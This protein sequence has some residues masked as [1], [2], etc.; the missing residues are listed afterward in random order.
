MKRIFAAALAAAV[1]LS[2]VFAAAGCA[3][4]GGGD[5]PPDYGTL[6]IADVSVAV[7]E[8][9]KLEPVFSKGDPLEITY[10]FD[11]SDIRIEDDTV[12]A[13]VADKTV[14]VTATTEHHSTTFTVTTTPPDYGKLVINDV[15]T[16][17]DYFPSDFVPVYTDADHAGTEIDYEYDESL[18]SLDADN[19]TVTAL[20]AGTATVKATLGAYQT[21]FTVNCLPAVSMTGSIKRSFPRHGKAKRTTA[22]PPPSSATPSSIRVIFGRIST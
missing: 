4:D 21:S 22:F 1:A 5:T 18:I 12:Y 16:W 3:N 15:N 11:G 13:L 8:S 6:T 20:K 17:V 2:L 9:A 19:C 10:T 7:G 14:E